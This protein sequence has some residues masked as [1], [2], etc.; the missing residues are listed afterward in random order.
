MTTVLWIGI[1]LASS[2]LVWSVFNFVRYQRRESQ[3]PVHAVGAISGNAATLCLLVGMIPQQD[4]PL[5]WILLLGGLLF[6]L[7]SIT[8]S[9]VAWRRRRELQRR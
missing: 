9:I 4:E 8:L 1:A 2:A 3:L 7:V 5:R 6:L